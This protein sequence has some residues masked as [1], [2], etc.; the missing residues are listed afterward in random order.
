MLPTNSH[1]CATDHALIASVCAWQR[2]ATDVRPP[3]GGPPDVAAAA[4]G[5]PVVSSS[6]GWP[7][8]VGGDADDGVGVACGAAATPAGGEPML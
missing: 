4:G 2:A 7:A 8:F 3:S 6:S 5:L 1:T